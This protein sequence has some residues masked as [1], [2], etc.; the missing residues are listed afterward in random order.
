[1]VYWSD[2]LMLRYHI[3]DRR[4]REVLWRYG[5]IPPE[6]P[7]T[8]DSNLKIRKMMT[9]TR[10]TSD[11]QVMPACKRREEKGAVRN[12]HRVLHN[13]K[14]LQQ[15]ASFKP[16]SFSFITESSVGN[17][18]VKCIN[19]EQHRRRNAVTASATYD[20]FLSSVILLLCYHEK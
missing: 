7:F 14:K 6:L 9:K 16:Q 3:T 5:T 15:I 19:Q 18:N 12:F 4:S 2:I 1:M 20:N 8:L 17:S 11:G 10:G 13:T